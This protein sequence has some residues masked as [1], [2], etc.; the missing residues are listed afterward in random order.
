MYYL[1]V[2]KSPDLRKEAVQGDVLFHLNI[3]ARGSLTTSMLAS[4]LQSASSMTEGDA[5]L[6]VEAILE[7]IKDAILQGYAIELE[8]IGTFQL[9][10]S[11][12][13]IVD[14]ADFETASIRMP[15]VRFRAKPTLKRR[16]LPYLRFQIVNQNRVYPNNK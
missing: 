8:D 2:V 15:H 9:F 11:A 6:I 4:Q 16:V 14:A 12:P 1:N 13:G 3:A 7:N 10:Y 5:I